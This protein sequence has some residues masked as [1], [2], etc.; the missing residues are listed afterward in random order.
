MCACDMDE[1]NRMLRLYMTVRE[2]HGEK[3]GGIAKKVGERKFG[4]VC[5]IAKNK[6]TLNK[7]LVEEK[8][9]PKSGDER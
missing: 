4:R 8:V 2:I 9:V 6:M 7:R 3:G 5:G 1:I